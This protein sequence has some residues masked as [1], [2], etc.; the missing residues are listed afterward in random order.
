MLGDLKKQIR[1]LEAKKARLSEKQDEQK[2]DK[3][4]QYFTKLATRGLGAERAS[5]FVVDPD[6]HTVWLKAGT[7]LEQYAIEVSTE[8]SIVGEVIRSG[9]SIR[10][11]RLDEAKGAHRETDEQTGFVTRDILCVP[12]RDDREKKVVGAIQAL[13]RIDGEPFDETDEAALLEMAEHIRDHVNEAYL[14]QELYSLSDKVVNGA[15]K[16][17]NVLLFA[18]TL[19]VIYAIFSTVF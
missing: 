7:G 2:P 3:L 19:A 15:Q 1:K 9:E 8:D 18:L 14:E 4:L 5:I 12:I 13:N 16:V 11:S 10:R 17:V 6:T